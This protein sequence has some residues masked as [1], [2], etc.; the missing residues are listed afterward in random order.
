MLSSSAIGAMVLLGWGAFKYSLLLKQ[1]THGGVL[2]TATFG[3]AMFSVCGAI[4]L[5]LAW[6]LD[7]M[8][9]NS[10]YAVGAM[11]VAIYSVVGN[12][13]A[14]H[15]ENSSN[16]IRSLAPV[17]VLLGQYV[18][19][20]ASDLNGVTNVVMLGLANTVLAGVLAWVA[21]VVFKRKKNEPLF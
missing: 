15:A 18:R 2:L 9:N 8:P 11:A 14:Y 7:T 17:V 21:V 1:L 4:V 5:V 20:V 12:V 19:F 13:R 10:E 3:A 16:A 6:A